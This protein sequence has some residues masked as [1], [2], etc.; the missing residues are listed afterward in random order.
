MRRD[1]VKGLKDRRRSERNALSPGT[2]L[3]SRYKQVHGGLR[4]R[5]MAPL[6]EVAWEKQVGRLIILRS[7]KELS[8]RDLRRTLSV[9]NIGNGGGLI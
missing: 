4:R 6:N 1:S 5:A 3:D 8:V 2:R 7:L 9:N